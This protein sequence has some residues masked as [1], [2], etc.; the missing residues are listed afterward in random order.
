MLA[1]R[2]FYKAKILFNPKRATTTLITTSIYKITRNP[3]YL[4]FILFY[5][6]LSLL[7]SSIWMLV[8]VVPAIYFIQKF[9]IEVEEKLLEAK[10][11]EKFINYTIRVPRWI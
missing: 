3:M 1:L 11:G 7:F 5:I 10:Y 8:M 2:E 4:S 9:S 6:G